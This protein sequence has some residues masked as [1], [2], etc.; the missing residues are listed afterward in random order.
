MKRFLKLA[1]KILAVT[2]VFG[3]LAAAFVYFQGIQYSLAL[4]T[5]SLR[6]PYFD[7]APYATDDN[8]FGREPCTS[9][10][11]RVLTYNIYCRICTDEQHDPWDVRIPHLRN[12]IQR[13]DPDLIGSQELGG[14][15]D[16]QEFLPDETTYGIVSFEFGPWTYGDSALFYRKSRYE[17]LDSGQFWLSPNPELPFGF[18]WLK[19]SAPRYLTWACLRDRNNGFTFLF[20]NSHL[21]NNPLNKESSAPLIFS[22]FSPV[23]EQMPIIFT[24]DFN[25]SPTT[26]RYNVLRKGYSE[27]V[28]FHNAA[29]ITARQAECIYTADTLPPDKLADFQHFEHTI[30]HIFLAGPV[31]KEVLRWVVDRN[32]YGEPQRQASDHPAIFAEIRLTLSP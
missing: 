9:D 20:M 19:L 14:W 30:D 21:D 29:D 23:S 16:I 25:T 10:I 2:S 13:Y 18:G 28:V 15:K 24:G 17:L 27:N 6:N 1:G 12:M 32:I 26:E 8:C 5:G 3:L 7:A 22:R 31:K 4:L 11:V